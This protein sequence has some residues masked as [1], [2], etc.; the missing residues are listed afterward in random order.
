MRVRG[1]AL[2]E[3]DVTRVRRTSSSLDGLDVVTQRA[4]GA[5]K[6]RRRVGYIYPQ[7]CY[8]LR[9]H[10]SATFAACVRSRSGSKKFFF[11]SHFA[12]EVGTEIPKAQR[13]C[14]VDA[15]T[16]RIVEAGC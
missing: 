7:R 12:V 16:L 5:L 14:C 13:V 9:L 6:A 15:L 11:F 4:G 2:R 8:L 1:P 10:S 3:N